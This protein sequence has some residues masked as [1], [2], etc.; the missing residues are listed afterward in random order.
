MS[1]YSNNP[2]FSLQTANDDLKSSI[3]PQNGHP[4]G[5][6][7][8]SYN[9][10]SVPYADLYPQRSNTASNSYNHSK[11]HA[12][13]K[14]NQNVLNAPSS[15]SHRPTRPYIPSYTRLTYT[16]PPLPLPPPSEC[17]LEALTGRKPSAVPSY[18]DSNQFYF[19]MDD[20]RKPPYSYAML[21]G[22][23]IL[24]SPERRLTLSAIYDWIS[25]TFSFY[26]KS[27]NG[28]QNSVRHNLSLNK[29]F[30]KVER[31]KNLPGK[32]HFWAIRPGYEDQFQ[33]LRLRKSCVNPRPAPPIFEGNAL[34]SSSVPNYTASLPKSQDGNS[35]NQY[36]APSVGPARRYVQSREISATDR[37][38]F[39]EYPRFWNPRQTKVTDNDPSELETKFSDLGVSPIMSTGSPQSAVQSPTPPVSSPDSSESYR[40]NTLDNKTEISINENELRTPNKVRASSLA[41]EETVGPIYHTLDTNTNAS[42]NENYVD[43]L[44]TREVSTLAS[45][46]EDLDPPSSL[47]ASPTHKSRIIKPTKRSVSIDL[48]TPPRTLCPR[49]LSISDDMSNNDFNK[50]SLLS[51]IK[52]DSNTQFA[53]PSTNLK[54]HRNRILQMLA[55]P[56]AKQF[57]NITNSTETDSWNFTPFRPSSA[58]NDDILS[59]SL[60]SILKNDRFKSDLEKLKESDS[61]FV[62]TPTK[63]QWDNNFDMFDG[64]FLEAMDMFNCDAMPSNVFSP[65]KASPIKREV[66]RKHVPSSL[67]LTR[68]SIAQD[69]SYLPSPTKRKMPQLGRQA[70]TMF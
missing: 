32:G 3:P 1:N 36:R 13:G 65:I 37:N 33:K 30:M 69:D 38:A 18:E 39:T 46:K 25:G 48:P 15:K 42:H 49:A 24:C 22:M 66:R 62:E 31:S 7:S 63:P 12:S 23:S 8:I 54:E 51:P 59:H 68:A 50:S 67:V 29:A 35:F 60:Q 53:S 27:N 58:P 10:N 57:N 40:L 61:S 56:D 2:F 11:Y 41:L 16:V 4:P 20:G 47:P 43:E 9:P 14:E 70:S 6:S 34:I 26:S 19:P 28:W 55:T 45:E 5:I 64:D 17:S 44:D 21:I 52:F